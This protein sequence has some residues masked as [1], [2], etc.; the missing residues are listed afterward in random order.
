MSANRLVYVG[1]FIM[2]NQHREHD[3]PQLADLGDSVRQKAVRVSLVMLLCVVSM[4]VATV[5]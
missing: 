4:G 3:D 2:S 1:R 5:S